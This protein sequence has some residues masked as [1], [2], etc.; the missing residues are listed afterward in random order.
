MVAKPFLSEAGFLLIGLAALFSTAS[1][2]NATLFGT[3]RLGSVMTKDKALP[4]VFGFRRKQNE[5][6]R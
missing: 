6:K 5:V 2:I 4:A 3:A 1:A